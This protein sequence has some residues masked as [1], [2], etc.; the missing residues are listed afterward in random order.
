M[1]GSI[2]FRVPN[3]ADYEAGTVDVEVFAGDAAVA[4]DLECRWL[5]THVRDVDTSGAMQHLLFRQHRRI[6][7]PVR[8]YQLDGS[9][10]VAG[11]GCRFRPL[12]AAFFQDG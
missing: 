9:R 2:T 10:P 8:H 5:T 1:N 7:G 3:A 12:A 6:R 11:I 4:S